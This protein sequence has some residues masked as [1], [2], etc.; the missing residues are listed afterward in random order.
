MTIEA[1]HENVPCYSDAMQVRGIQEIQSSRCEPDEE[2][3]KLVPPGFVGEFWDIN[4]PPESAQVI[5]QM[6]QQL[7]AKKAMLGKED[8]NVG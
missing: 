8:R 2:L 6:L 3:L 7:E 5:I 1:G 4:I